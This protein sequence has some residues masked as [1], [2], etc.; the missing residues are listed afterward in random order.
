MSFRTW[1]KETGRQPLFAMNE[2]TESRQWREFSYMIAIK[3]IWIRE[4]LKSTHND[5]RCRVCLAPNTVETA[6][7][8]FVECEW[9]RRLREGVRVKLVNQSFGIEE[10]L[11]HQGRLHGKQEED[12][13]TI[14][15]RAIWILR[16]KRINVQYNAKIETFNQLAKTFNAIVPE[17]KNVVLNL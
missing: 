4:R 15:K 14:Y 1:K 5:K 2:A 13:T 3:G 6:L 10:I 12:S 16:I 9:I 11:Y 7:H 8:L 17:C